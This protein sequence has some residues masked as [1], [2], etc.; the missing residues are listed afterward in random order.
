MPL[1]VVRREARHLYAREPRS[2]AA[3]Q[4]VDALLGVQSAEEQQIERAR[5]A[6]GLTKNEF[7]AIRYLLQAQRDE[8]AMGPKDLV[9][10]L[11]VSNASVTKI[12]DEL[13]RKGDLRRV[14]HPSDRRAQ[15][16]EPSEQAARKIDAA[17]ERFHESVVDV[18]D[19]LSDEDN[20]VVTR[21]L[22]TL[23]TAMAERAAAETASTP[24]VPADGSTEQEQLSDHADAAR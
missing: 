18:F 22:T 9:V 3:R 21:V 20:A 8:R 13:E 15:V 11:N 19:R 14:A 7:H 4:A 16:L 10:M 1:T 5:V 6:S 24:A 17:Y 2:A 23:T 12:V